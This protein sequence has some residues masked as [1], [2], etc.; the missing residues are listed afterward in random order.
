M[1][2][3]LVFQT[4]KFHTTCIASCKLSLI[5]KHIYWSFIIVFLKVISI[6]SVFLAVLV[7][8]QHLSSLIFAVRYS[9]MTFCIFL[10]SASLWDFLLGS[11]NFFGLICGAFLFSL[12]ISGFLFWDTV[13]GLFNQNCHSP[14][15]DDNQRTADRNC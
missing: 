9:I 10:S 6:Q 5:F 4:F 12:S 3:N 13:H 11:L 15:K 2:C 14:N 1:V 7:L 8:L